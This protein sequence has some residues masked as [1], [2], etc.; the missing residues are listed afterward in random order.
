MSFILDALKKLEQEKA[1]RKGGEINISNE[2]IRDT[3]PL[4]RKTKRTVPV[5]AVLIVFGLLILAGASG[6]Y[7]WHKHG[8]DTKATIASVK[9]ERVPS[10]A[11]DAASQDRQA[12]AR[13]TAPPAK[14]V[15]TAT[16]APLPRE[17]NRRVQGERSAAQS[18]VNTDYEFR[19]KEPAREAFG[20]GGLKITVSGIA[21]QDAPAARR[22]VING[23]L[24]Q[25]G[26]QVG[27]ATVEEILPTRVRFSSGGRHFSV[28]ISGPLVTK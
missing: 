28:S 13:P 6:A 11:E 4:R 23:D 16:T 10:P 20:S 12:V 2:I 7:L 15:M 17:T 26:A 5:S 19:S 3:R 22:A 24:V 27:G 8:I 18:T 21:W 1:A 25:E 14:P 9:Y